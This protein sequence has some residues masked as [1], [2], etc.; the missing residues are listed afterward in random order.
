[1]TRRIPV[2][3]RFI[4]RGGGLELQRLESG[5]LERQEEWGHAV[6]S[7]ARAGRPGGD[8]QRRGA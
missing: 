5:E 4:T 1:M 2:A 6:G 3:A 7:V 8:V